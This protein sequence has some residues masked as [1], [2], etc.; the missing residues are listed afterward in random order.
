MAVFAPSG[1]GSQG[2][3]SQSTVSTATIQ[4]ITLA[5]ATTEYTITIPANSKRFTLKTRNNSILK[6]SYTSGQSGINYFTIG[7]G[8]C[9]TE[10]S[11]DGS[12][13]TLYLQ[14]SKDSTIIEVLSWE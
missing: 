7:Y 8:V 14:S 10:D 13:L 6:V 5:T 11:L 9:Y 4:N 2:G 3:S 1:S 12:S